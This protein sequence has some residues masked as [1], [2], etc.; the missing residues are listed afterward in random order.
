ML[1]R[2][3][4]LLGLAG[5]LVQ[6]Q[7]ISIGLSGGVPISAHST[8][9]GHGCIATRSSVGS[10]SVMTC[11]PN[12]LSM[13]PY[14][15]GPAVAAKLPWSLSIHAEMLYERY[16]RDVAHGLQVGRG[17]S[18]VNFGE[19]F[20]ASANGW[21]FPLS[22]QYGFGA[23]RLAPFVS[24]GATLRHLGAFKGRGTQVDFYLQPQP[25]AV[26]IETGR[27][28]DVAET[29]GAGVRWRWGVVDVSPEV[30]FLHWT[31]DYYQPAQN[32]VMLMVTIMGPI[33]GRR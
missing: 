23:G 17:I 15:V 6:A 13:K 21:L 16:H 22:L 31:S 5:A 24:A 18:A 12:R 8:D 14:A 29:V 20:G 25:V 30:R 11:G 4:M 28:L 2:G 9:F 3:L 7:V 33:W 19:Y 10:V 27:A 1:K 32:Q 26:H